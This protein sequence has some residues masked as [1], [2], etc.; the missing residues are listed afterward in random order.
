M[1]TLYV[2][3]QKSNMFVKTGKVTMVTVTYTTIH[4]RVFVSPY[5]RNDLVECYRAPSN[6]HTKGI[7][8]R[9]NVAKK[10][11]C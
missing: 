6:H 1:R 10:N 5:S 4:H 9:D 8:E 11:L 3:R 7:H 2:S